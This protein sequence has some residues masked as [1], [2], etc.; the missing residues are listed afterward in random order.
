LQDGGLSSPRLGF[1]GVEDL[2]GGT[3]ANFLLESELS[4]R[5]GGNNGLSTNGSSTYAGPQMFNRGSWVG[6]SNNGFGETRLGYQNGIMYDNA[7]EF[8]ALKGANMGGTINVAS[9][10][11]S[12]S[13]GNIYKGRVADRLASSYAYITPTFMG[14]SGKIVQGSTTLTGPNGVNAA[15]GRD[16]EYGVRYEGYGAK[17]AVTA[18]SLAS[19]NGAALTQTSVAGSKAYGIYAIYDFKILEVNAARTVTTGQGTGGGN[20]AQTSF[21]VRAPVTPV[22]TVGAQA[23]LVNNSVLANANANVV[24]AVAEYS[25]SKRTTLYALGAVSS[26][27]N[28]GGTSMTST[29]KFSAS[30]QVSSTVTGLNQT[31]YMIGM[32]HTF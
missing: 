12:A 11:A 24:A 26:N 9:A 21:G 18:A 30:T 23:T 29:S 10:G 16:T 14:F 3:K 28:A 4:L 32:R 20:Y 27:Q 1:K 6:L 2:G 7:G 8:D 19:T 5:N 25:M 22:I 31:G 15:A 17:V 13:T